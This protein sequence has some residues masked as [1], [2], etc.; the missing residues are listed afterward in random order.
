M[1]ET[2]KSIAII[3]SSLVALHVSYDSDIDL[4][5]SLILEVTN[6][7]PIPPGEGR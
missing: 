6:N 4:A 3:I 2:G 1:K 5:R 7:L